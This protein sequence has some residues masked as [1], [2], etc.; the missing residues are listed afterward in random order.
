MFPLVR[1]NISKAEKKCFENEDKEQLL[2][3]K[4]VKFL[5][6]QLRKLDD[7][8]KSDNIFYLTP[9]I[10]EIKEEDCLETMTK[11]LD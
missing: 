9:S 4:I 2:N 8:L 5:S 3:S 10:E 6:I 11:C 1:L 7:G